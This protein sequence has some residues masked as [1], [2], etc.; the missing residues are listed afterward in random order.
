MTLQRSD[1]VLHRRLMLRGTIRY[2]GIATVVVDFSDGTTGTF[3]PRAAS[4]VLELLAV[5]VVA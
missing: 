1:T 2:A 3:E 4:L 5:D